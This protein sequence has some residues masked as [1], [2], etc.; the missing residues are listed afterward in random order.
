MGG[1]EGKNWELNFGHVN[2]EI[3]VRDLQVS[4]SRD[5]QKAFQYKILESKKELVSSCWYVD[6]ISSCETGF[7]HL[8]KY[9]T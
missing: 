2:F 9:L 6:R 8:K 3:S 1:F 4:T 7:D 5:I